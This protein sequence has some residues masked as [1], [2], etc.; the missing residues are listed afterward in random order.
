MYSLMNLL[1]KEINILDSSEFSYHEESSAVID[2][3]SFNK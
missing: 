2:S 1:N 3:V